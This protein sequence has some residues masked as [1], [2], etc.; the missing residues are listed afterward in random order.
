MVIAAH[1]EVLPVIHNVAA[2]ESIKEYARPPR[3]LRRS[4]KWTVAP[5]S[6]SLTPAA[7]QIHLRLLHPLGHYFLNLP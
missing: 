3:W 4:S 2:L 5:R 7:R 6:L 1:E